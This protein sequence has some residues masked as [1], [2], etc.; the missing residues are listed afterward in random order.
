[1]SLSVLENVAET[2]AAKPGAPVRSRSCRHCG[3][4]S[5]DEEFCC[6]G[7]AYVFR[8]IH[9]EGLEAYYRIKDDVTAPADSAIGPSR[10]YGW[11]RARQA[12]AE[13]EVK[14]IDGRAPRLTLAVQGLSCAG[15]GWLI[16]RLFQKAPGAGRIEIDAA[17]GL[18]R[19]RWTAGEFDAVAWA[20]MLQRFNYV[21]G[22]AGAVSEAPVQRNDLTRRI[23]L[24]GAF[25]MN[26]ML[27]TLPAYFGMEE[28]FAYA[29]LFGTLALA[30]ATLSVLAGGGYFVGRAVR[31]LRE[32]AVHIDLPIAIGIVGAYVGSF[33]GWASGQ[34]AY[35]YFDFV[36]TFILLMLVGRWA[37]V[38]AVERN[39]RRLLREQPMTPPVRVR[40]ADG[41]WRDAA[42]DTLRAGDRFAVGSGA[43]VPVEAT[44]ES[45]EAALSLAWI[46]GESEPKV[47]R[48]GQ[49][50]PAG[51]E[52]V[53]RG[54]LELTAR[55][56][57][58]TS[59]LA[60]LLQPVERA[61]AG[62][63]V[64][65]RVVRGY[66]IGIVGLALAAAVAW[67]WRTG[68]L[69]RTGAIVTAVLVVSCP[70][71]LGL[72]WPLADEI[73]T[74]A[75]RRRG[76]F[77][78]RGDVWTRLAKVRRLV[79]D[80]TGTLTM[81]TPA[82][83]DADAVLGALSDDERAAVAALVRDNPH[84]VARALQ[85][86]LLARYAVTPLAGELEET[87]G[88]GVS[89]GPWRL[90][91]AGWA[92][93]TSSSAGN[94]GTVLSWGGQVVARFEFVDE[95]R[96]DAAQELAAL[97]SRGL[98][99]YVL[100]GDAQAKVSALAAQLDLPADRAVGD[101]SPRDK[102]AWL[103]RNGAEHATM[104][105]DGAN[106]SLAFDRALVRG[107][108][109]IH[110]GALEAKA[111]FYYLGRGIGGLRALFEVAEQ[112]RRVL[113]ALIGFSVVYNLAAVA[114]ALAGA[115]NPLLAAVLMPASSLVTLAIVGTGLRGVGRG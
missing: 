106:D 37:Q 99:A 107:T 3:A 47:F 31:A 97:E 52:N 53:T 5:K 88:E 113:A 69:Q 85:E 15:C 65:D 16:E 50:V 35:Q 89:L 17:R 57:W 95:A 80:K 73:A 104:L 87:I 2:S 78:R 115:M 91:R 76:V 51:A 32:G 62:Q 22:P 77:L 93:E 81:E 6:A 110:R 61:D 23:G 60:E 70:C 74:V 68:D 114:V 84:P 59:L 40:G 105:G 54:A 58:E 10:D 100:S 1:M 112:R 28:T 44:L 94:R 29:G 4:D 101:Q 108:P 109:V 63:G 64:I 30:F 92:A 21:V 14:A 90:G 67:G 49:T 55:Q 102:A 36:G 25:A 11:L 72:A 24:C 18:M 43:T 75:L 42:A 20:E 34:A 45:A 41:T 48:A 9:A 38:G 86:A 66:V 19:L 56:G 111:D 39:Q 33:Y 96:V 13:D 83:Q 103:E 82:L 27:F 46:N 71:A 79:F 7:C 26:I 98:A 12:E 8:L